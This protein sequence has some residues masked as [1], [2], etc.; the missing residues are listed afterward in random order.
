MRKLVTPNS[1]IIERL[2]TQLEVYDVNYQKLLSE[3]LELKQENKKLEIDVASLRAM[4]RYCE[5][6]HKE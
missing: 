1:E 5:K 4:V 3:S 2:Q 6:H